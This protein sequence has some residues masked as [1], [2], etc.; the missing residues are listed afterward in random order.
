MGWRYVIGVFYHI[1]LVGFDFSDVEM[2][3]N[4][5]EIVRMIK[6]RKQLQLVHD[7]GH[8]KSAPKKPKAQR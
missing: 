3:E 6:E 7:L 4:V 5:R 2:K 8:S 1:Q